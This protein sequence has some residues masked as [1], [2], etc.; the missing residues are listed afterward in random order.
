MADAGDVWE[1]INPNQPQHPLQKPEKPVRP[2][3]IVHPD[4]SQTE[5]TQQA[6]TLYTQDSSNYYREFKE[7][8]RLKD[9][10]G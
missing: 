6:L 8:R 2:A 7:Y 3:T 1:Y 10:L 5:P 4:G 9:K